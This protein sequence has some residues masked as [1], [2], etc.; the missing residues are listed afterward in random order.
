MRKSAKCV[1]SALLMFCFIGNVKAAECDY[2]KQVELNDLASTVKVTYE[3]V[4]IDTGE[5]Y[6]DDMKFDENG[7][8]IIITRKVKGFKVKLINLAE[9][10]SVEVSNDLGLNKFISYE[11]TNKGMVEL[12]T[13]T[14]DKIINYTI[15]VS[16]ETGVCA[17]QELRTINVLVPKYNLYS[18]TSYCKENPGFE[19]CKEYTTD[20]NQMDYI[21]FDEAAKKYDLTKEKKEEKKEQT[22][23]EKVLEVLNE[24][25]VIIISSVSIIVILTTGIIVV[26]RRR[27]L[28]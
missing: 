11:D 25:K 21:Q 19:Y 10:L 26:K 24:N 23:L 17:G 9:N 27:R 14:A 28:I 12:A 13:D 18:E 3:E 22:K 1:L 20:N 8:N 5:Q 7:N 16:V 6:I 2:Q 4:E 15:N